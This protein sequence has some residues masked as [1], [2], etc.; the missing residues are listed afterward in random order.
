V[1]RPIGAHSSPRKEV[2]SKVEGRAVIKRGAALWALEAGLAQRERKRQSGV[3]RWGAAVR[4]REVLKED[5]GVKKKTHKQRLK[6]LIGVYTL[7][8]KNLYLGLAEGSTP[9]IATGGGD[10]LEGNFLRIKEKNSSIV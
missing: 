5:S 3:K 2:N 6:K 1:E 7:G 8:E 10:F 9:I 4:G